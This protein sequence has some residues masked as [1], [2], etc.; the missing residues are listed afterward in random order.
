[1]SIDRESTMPTFDE[2]QAQIAQLQEQ[3]NRM[4]ETE[5]VAAIAD[6][7]EKIAKY[8]ITAT[9]LGF[10]GQSAVSNK[11][12]SAKNKLDAKYRDPETGATWSGRGRVPQW[13]ASKNKDDY[14]IQP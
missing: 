7:K 5:K 12:S 9:E 8:G 13:L 1:M 14:L 10:R 11:A 4:R 2:L 6:M 3:A